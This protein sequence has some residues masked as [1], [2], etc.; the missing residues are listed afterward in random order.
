MK[1]TNLQAGGV[2]S[3]IEFAFAA[4]LMDYGRCADA[5]KIV[6]AVHRQLRFGGLS[7]IGQGAGEM[8]HHLGVFR[9][10]S[11]CAESSPTCSTRS[12]P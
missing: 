1:L 12:M 6:E 10:E 8:K 4:L 3:G 5:V 2:W 11:G 7:R 9:R